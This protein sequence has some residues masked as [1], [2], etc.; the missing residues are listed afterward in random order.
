MA[1]SKISCCMTLTSLPNVCVETQESDFY[2][3]Q[4]NDTRTIMSVK[5]IV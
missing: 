2:C 4:L 5:K 1:S 3:L